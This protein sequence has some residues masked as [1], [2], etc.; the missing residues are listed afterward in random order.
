[1][2][3]KI[4]LILFVICNMILNHM[5]LDL[6]AQSQS[7]FNIG[8]VYSVGASNIFRTNSMSG[9]NIM[10]TEAQSNMGIKI[11]FGAGLK[12]EYFFSD[13]WGMFFQTGFQQRGAIFSEYRDNDKPVYQLNYWDLLAGGVFR[14]KGLMK[15]HHLIINLGVSEHTLLS[16]NRVYDTGSDN[17]TDDFNSVDIGLYLAISENIPIR[18]KDIFQFQL[19]ANL[20]L[21]Q[22]FKGNLAMNQMSGRN[23]VTGI[24]IG[25][26]IGETGLK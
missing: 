25:Y 24:Q 12:A 17:I 11:N 26:L 5:Y 19:Y 2:L 15:N 13:N 18:G 8:P 7:T 21:L 3:N 9:M 10:D 4:V 23:F 1:M 22:V 6:K 14:S 20:G 16:A